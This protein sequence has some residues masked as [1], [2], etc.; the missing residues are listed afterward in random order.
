M[1]REEILSIDKYW[2]EQECGKEDEIKKFAVTV[3]ALFL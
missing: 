3:D 2:A 1:T